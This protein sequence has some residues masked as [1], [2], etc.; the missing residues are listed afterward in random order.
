MTLPKPFRDITIQNILMVNNRM[1]IIASGRSVGAKSGT[2]P[3]WM[4]YLFRVSADMLNC[5]VVIPL[6]S[7]NVKTEVTTCIVEDRYVAVLCSKCGVGGTSRQRTKSVRFFTTDTKTMKQQEHSRGVK[8]EQFMFAIKNEVFLT[9]QGCYRYQKFD[10][11]TRRWSSGKDILVPHPLDEPS[12]SD[13]IYSTHQ[14]ELYVIGG[15]SGKNLLTSAC[16]YDLENRKWETLQEAPKAITNSG[17]VV[18]KIPSNLVRCHIDCPHCKYF[19]VRSQATYQIDYP[20]D[21]PEEDEDL[22]YDDEDVY[23]DYWENDIYD[24]YGNIPD[25]DWF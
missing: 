24:E 4:V 14:S 21:D 10:I 5:D 17:V 20:D 25:Y 22:S 3:Q 15:K 13:F 7:R 6:C 11:N 19:G 9:K 1:Y 8:H 23:S 18:A 2:L 16:K 12:R